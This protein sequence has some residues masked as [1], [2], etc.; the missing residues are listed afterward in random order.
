MRLRGTPAFVMAMAGLSGCASV[1]SSRTDMPQPGYQCA[2]DARGAFGVVSSDFKVRSSGRIDGA[3][4]RWDAGDGNFANPWITGAWFWRPDDRFS[5]DYGYVSIMRHIWE[6]QPGKQPRPLKLTLE[7]SATNAPAMRAS[8]LS[9][10]L[11]SSGGPFHLQLNWSDAAAMGRGS[12]HLYLIARN[13]SLEIVD[14]VEI[15]RAMF[16]RAEPHI[17]TAFE[18]VE[19]MLADPAKT[20]SY[21]EDLRE[22]DIIVT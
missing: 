11:E 21:V 12:A 15:D 1:Q 4:V 6:N 7:L 3:Y 22:D 18:A 13:S 17:R 5:L 8:R 19:R 14:Q 20:C 16:E 2:Y 10:D 9:G